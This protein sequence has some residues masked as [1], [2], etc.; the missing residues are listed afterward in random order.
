M[1]LFSGVLPNATKTIATYGII[2]QATSLI[3]NF[4]YALCLDVS[5]KGGNELGANRPDILQGKG[6]IVLCITMCF[7]YNRCVYTMSH[8]L[9]QMFTKDEAILSLIA[10]TLPIVGLCEIGNC[11]QTIIYGY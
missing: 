2:I 11:P 8:V 5:T 3:Y 9:G 7:H 4:P 1:V 10:T 6:I